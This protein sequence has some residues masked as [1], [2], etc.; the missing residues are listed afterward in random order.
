MSI[1]GKIMG[2]AEKNNA[3]LYWHNGLTPSFV[4]FYLLRPQNTVQYNILERENFGKLEIFLSKYFFLK[5]E[6]FNI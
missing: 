2:I 5:A 1:I 6:I 4:Y 3:Q